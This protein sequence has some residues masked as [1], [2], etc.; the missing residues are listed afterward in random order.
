MT[1]PRGTWWMRAAAVAYDR[2]RSLT[3]AISGPGFVRPEHEVDAA[4]QSEGFA[5][6]LN[7]STW[8]WRVALYRRLPV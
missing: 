7:D 1:Y 8:Y 2:F 4:I 5:R 3:G 6:V